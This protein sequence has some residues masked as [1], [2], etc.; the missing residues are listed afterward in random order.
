M[1][2]AIDKAS[3]RQLRWYLNEKY[4]LDQH[5]TASKANMLAKLR[6]YEQSSKDIDVPDNATL[7]K[8]EQVDDAEAAEA[9]PA[10]VNGKGAVKGI[11]PEMLVE[12][13]VAQG[14]DEDQARKIADRTTVAEQQTRG[15]PAGGDPMRHWAIIEVQRTEEAG[16]S[17]PV[18]VIPNGMAQ[19]LERGRPIEVRWPYVEVLQH[20]EKIVYDE[21]LSLGRDAPRA[22]SAD[23]ADLPVPDPGRSV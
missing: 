17:D 7:A 8:I 11:D 21:K 18:Q 10:P 19:L 4:G 23:R 9:A 5:K 22:H 2:V 15:L 6:K 3:A 20:A 12:M 14:L 1:K 13:L 16:G